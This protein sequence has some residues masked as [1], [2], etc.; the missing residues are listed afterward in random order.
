M[1]DFKKPSF[2]EWDDSSTP[3]VPMLP[4]E[5]P[6]RL[7]APIEVRDDHVLT[8]LDVYLDLLTDIF[9][10]HGQLG[11]GEIPIAVAVLHKLIHTIVGLCL[12]LALPDV[13]ANQGVLKAESLCEVSCVYAAW[14]Q[15]G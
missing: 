4:S 6:L 12:G 11:Q 3:D 5:I 9:T 15:M 13:D 2:H 7:E 14:F 1:P 10:P 8:A